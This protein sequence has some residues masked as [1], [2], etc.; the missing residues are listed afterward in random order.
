MTISAYTDPMAVPRAEAQLR[1]LERTLTRALHGLRDRVAS[2]ELAMGDA[3]RTLADRWALIHRLQHETVALLSAVIPLVDKVPMAYR[4][5]PAYRDVMSVAMI[6][7]RE[8]LAAQEL[9][10]AIAHDF[11]HKDRLGGLWDQV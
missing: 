2:L 3:D 11:P 7:K 5:H 1:D 8:A 6:L 4:A 9:R 10:T